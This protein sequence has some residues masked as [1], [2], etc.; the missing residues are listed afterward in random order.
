MDACY[1]CGRPGH[2]ARDCHAQPCPR[3]AV[4]ASRHTGLGTIECAWRGEPCATCGH[5]PHPDWAPGRCPR[6]ASPSD[7][8][9]DRAV[10]A[11]SDWARDED[12]DL[13]YRPRAVAVR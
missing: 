10:R 2:W 9:A 1:K 13:F 6:Y 12:P 5:P 3:C 11:A 7:T 4:P 8:D